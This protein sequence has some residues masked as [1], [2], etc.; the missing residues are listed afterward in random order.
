MAVYDIAAA[1]QARTWFPS[2][3]WGDNMQHVDLRIGQAGES[4]LPSRAW[5]DAARRLFVA[6]GCDAF[7]YAPEAGLQ[8]LRD[9]LSRFLTARNGRYIAPRELLIT[10]GA[11]HAIELMLKVLLPAGA[12]VAVEDPTYFLSLRIFKDWNVKLVPVPVERDGIDVNRFEALLTKQRID[13]LYSIP[14]NHNPTGV[15]LSESKR[16]AL[17]ALSD[18]RGV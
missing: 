7:Q 12:T 17:R 8:S 16:E 4:L 18:R 11:S 14:V 13:M 1:R 15:S 3:E 6:D 2:F 10:S 5:G 9:A